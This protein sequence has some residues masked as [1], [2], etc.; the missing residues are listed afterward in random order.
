MPAPT[1][2]LHTISAEDFAAAAEHKP[3]TQT[4]YFYKIEGKAFK[5]TALYKDIRQLLDYEPDDMDDDESQEISDYQQFLIVTDTAIPS[6]PQ[7]WASEVLYFIFYRCVLPGI[8]F[9]MGEHLRFLFINTQ[10]GTVELLSGT[11]IHGVSFKENSRCDYIHIDE[12]VECKHIAVTDG[13]RLG[14]I[15]L[16]G[17]SE[18]DNIY[19]G[20]NSRCDQIVIA[21][22]CSGKSIYVNSNSNCETIY[23]KGSCSVDF[24]RITDNSICNAVVI[25]E[26]SYAQHIY[27]TDGCKVGY[28]GISGASHGDSLLISNAQ[29]REIAING[30]SVID[31][32][33]ISE[34]GNCENVHISNSVFKETYIVAN[35]RVGTIN[36]SNNSYCAR[37][38][39]ADSRI[40]ELIANHVCG[41][42]ILENA[43]VSFMRFNNC[44]IHELTWKSGT[45]GE[46]Y[47]ENGKINHLRLVKTTLLKDSVISL[48]NVDVYIAQ[49]QELLIQGQLVCRNI[50]PASRPFELVA[51]FTEAAPAEDAVELE[52]KIYERKVQL[53][54]ELQGAYN[55]SVKVLVNE[56]KDRP[57]PLFRIADSSLGKTDITGSDLTGFC[58]EYRDSKLLET[59]LS[60]TKLPK[61]KIEIY[62]PTPAAQLPQRIYFEQKVSIYN[63]LKK[64]YDNLGDIVEATWYHSKA[65]DNQERLLKTKYKQEKS[66]WFG[67]QWF[68]LMTFKLNK[69]SNNHGESWR[70]ALRFI[71]TASLIMYSLYYICI[72]YKESPSLQATDRFVSNY[73]LFLDL[74]HK[75]DFHVDKKL[76]WWLPVLI[77][78]VARILIGYGIYQFIAA[79]RR[80]SRK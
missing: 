6:I 32:V 42:W 40:D 65:M 73:F 63:Q 9:H 17:D 35:S 60:G 62:N 30:N 5:Q 79:F 28:V 23:I 29:C 33:N 18:F 22:H 57:L 52:K 51:A 48:M 3:F 41:H 12:H 55:T 72:H 45:K 10:V 1:T 56:F 2:P 53:V 8:E 38:Y 50:R 19:I 47:I 64:I 61:E 68:D 11:Y 24:I 14:E 34:N 13:S 46:L 27:V 71:L 44:C 76:L 21:Q 36:A 54:K 75:V 25:D 66:K 4:D 80:H 26:K 16:D 39:V 7:A 70:L 15:L 69:V 37:I 58:F 43:V 67:E 59:F 78:F 49:L 31:K 77:D 20:G 74:T